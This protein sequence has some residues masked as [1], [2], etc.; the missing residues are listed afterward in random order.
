MSAMVPRRVIVPSALAYAMVALMPCAY[1]LSAGTLGAWR[2]VWLSPRQAGLLANT[3]ALSGLASLAA[4][5]LGAA[6]AILVART[7]LFGRRS[8][9]FAAVAQLF[10]APHLLAIA[11][12]Y[13][14]GTRFAGLAAAVAVLAISYYPLA[15]LI[16]LAG[17]ASVDSSQEEAALLVEDRGA[18]LRGITL[19]L[20]RPHVLASFIFV[21]LLC[22]VEYGVPDILR[23]NTYP[24]EIFAQ[25]SAYY[26]NAGAA[27]LSAPLVLVAFLLLICAQRLIG[28]RRFAGFGTSRMAPGVRMELRAWRIYIVGL[29]W[30]VCGASVLLPVSVFARQ[31]AS[32]NRSLVSMIG[33][34]PIGFSIAMAALGAT[35]ITL[36]AFPVAYA[37]ERAKPAGRN[38]IL[39]LG[40]LPLAI[41]ATV[42]G[43]GLIAL[44]NRDFGVPIYGSWVML[45]LGCTAR[46]SPFAVVVLAA[47]LKLVSRQQ[48]EAALLIAPGWLGRVLRIVTPQCKAGILAAWAIS[49][50]FCLGELGTSLL[51]MPPGTETLTLRLFNLMHYGA[52]DIVALLALLVVAGGLAVSGIL[53]V[54]YGWKRSE[55]WSG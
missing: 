29:V 10:I 18:V 34:A 2:R 33:S 28:R 43:I 20:V 36:L 39:L 22:L 24:V 15:F 7:D 13:L 38:W 9:F 19:R 25:F 12:Q 35:C 53:A 51:V 55:L 45:V 26:D 52:Q 6:L 23:L 49:F 32:S 42:V 4:V 14:F 40:L 1:M 37:A 5:A 17:L 50:V 11:G 48:E 44:W 27:A 21:S 46:F 3:I 30:T 8:V 16:V 41:P 47:S 31:V 54:M